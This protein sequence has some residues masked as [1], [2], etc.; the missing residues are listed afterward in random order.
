MSKET[1]SKNPTTSKNIEIRTPTGILSKRILEDIYG[2]PAEPLPL[3][4][5]GSTDNSI[6]QVKKSVKPQTEKGF[7]EVGSVPGT[8]AKDTTDYSYSTT[9]ISDPESS[10]D[11]PLVDSLATTLPLPST[12]YGGD[13]E[14]LSLNPYLSS[15]VG[16]LSFVDPLSP[17]PFS[18]RTSSVSQEIVPKKKLSLGLNS[19]KD[20]KKKISAPKESIDSELPSSDALTTATIQQSAPKVQLTTGPTKTG[21]SAS[22]DTLTTATTQQPAKIQLAGQTTTT[23]DDSTFS[24]FAD[25]FEL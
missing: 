16:S 18:S 2:T 12:C 25:D 10:E 8:R 6:E 21:Y 3:S 9:T 15:S 17:Y 5:T 22:S 19:E 23:V 1:S 7:T 13:S 20:P 24:V 14:K 4:F 11:E